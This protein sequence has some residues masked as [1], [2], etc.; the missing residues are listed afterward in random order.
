MPLLVQ[1][2]RFGLM[3]WEAQSSQLPW[4]TVPPAVG[5][6]VGRLIPEVKTG[7]TGLGEQDASVSFLLAFNLVFQSSFLLVLGWGIFGLGHHLRLSY[8]FQIYLVIPNKMIIS[9]LLLQLWDMRGLSIGLER[10]WVMAETQARGLIF[11]A[12]TFRWL[13]EKGVW[14]E[15][16]E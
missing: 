6:W 16:W 4:A 14:V 10:A 8:Y 3:P 5:R 11:P 15:D 12:F 13:V 9:F 2:C 1:W 7:A